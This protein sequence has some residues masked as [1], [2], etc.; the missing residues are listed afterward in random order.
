MKK[1]VSLLAVFIVFAFPLMSSAE[2]EILPFAFDLDGNSVTMT[3]AKAYKAVHAPYGEESKNVIL[4]VF[5]FDVSS[6][7]ENLLET[8]FSYVD[9]PLGAIKKQDEKIYMETNVVSVV[10]VKNKIAQFVMEYP[11]ETL[12]SNSWL[13]ALSVEGEKPV[14]YITDSNGTKTETS[15]NRYVIS[16]TFDEVSGFD[17]IDNDLHG[18]LTRYRYGIR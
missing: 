6:L 16:I 2:P 13:Y 4:I 14:A 3:S 5:D 17:S 12:S 7:P 18:I 9:V 1:L 11:E 8:F 10:W 15:E